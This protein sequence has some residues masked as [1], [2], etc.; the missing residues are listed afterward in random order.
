[1]KKLLI[2]L[3]ILGLCLTGCANPNT[4]GGAAIGGIAGAQIGNGQV[5][6]LPDGQWEIVN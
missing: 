4:I 2:L 1:M 6:R 3:A 5:C